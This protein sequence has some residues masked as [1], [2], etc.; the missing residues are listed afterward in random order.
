M[1]VAAEG[2]WSEQDTTPA[3]IEAALRKLLQEQYERDEACAP[4]RVINLVVVVDREWRGEVLN[5]LEKVGRY[6]PSRT[7]LCSVETGRTTIDASVALTTEGEA[8]RKAG[9][10]ALTRERLMLDLGPRHLEKLDTIV[11][12]LVVSDI[13]TVVWSPHG[14]PEAVDALLHL[15]QVVLLDSV[16]EPDP[17]AA[18]ERARELAREAYIV[19]LAWL[20][21]TPWRERVASTFDP[22]PWRDE[23]GRISSVAVRH[24]PQSGVAGLLF[25]GWLASRLGWEPG[26]LT[27]ANGSLKGRAHGRRQDVELELVPDAEMSVPGLAGIR[28]GTAS[29]MSISLDRGPGGL[30]A[31]REDSKGRT[32]TWTVLG[33]SRGESG[34]LGEGIRQALLRDPTYAR[35]LE[36]AGAMVR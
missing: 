18:V 9:D 23:L 19:D 30:S 3:A 26:S 15:T 25:C 14:H 35:A 16:N 21:S 6:H 36:Q 10:I 13:A 28:L 11:D 12:P 31:R 29:G 7:I 2:M 5:R 34:I 32:S 4:A 22:S 24:Q 1:T 27:S 20:R 17:A 8:G 33:A